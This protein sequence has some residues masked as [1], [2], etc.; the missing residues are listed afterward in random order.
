MTQ[1]LDHPTTPELKQYLSAHR[2]DEEV[3]R[4][5]LPVLM[6]RRDPNAPPQPYPFYP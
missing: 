1:N 5:G 6:S 4:L 2:N 3:F